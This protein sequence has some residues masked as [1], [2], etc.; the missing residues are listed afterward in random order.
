[1]KN[2]RRDKVPCR[3]PQLLFTRSNRFVSRCFLEKSTAD[4][5]L[6][7]RAMPEDIAAGVLLCG[8]TGGHHLAGHWFHASAANVH[9]ILCG[10]SAVVG[11]ATQG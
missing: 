3:H 1:M 10:G 2:D 4:P 5:S 6:G 7:G 8:M 11:E 9:P